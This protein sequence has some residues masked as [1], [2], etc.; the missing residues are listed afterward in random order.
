MRNCGERHL[1]P[2]RHVFAS[3]TQV[4]HSAEHLHFV[5]DGS[6]P[7]VAGWDSGTSDCVGA[8]DKLS[9]QVAFFWLNP[10]DVFSASLLPD[11]PNAKYLSQLV[12]IIVLRQFLC[13]FLVYPARN[14]FCVEGEPVGYFGVAHAQ[15]KPITSLISPWCIPAIQLHSCFDFSSWEGESW[16][17]PGS[18]AG[19]GTLWVIWVLW[20]WRN[21]GHMPSWMFQRST[22]QAGYIERLKQLGTALR[23]CIVSVAGV[24]WGNVIMRVSS[25][26]RI[27]LVGKP[28]ILGV[29]PPIDH[30]ILPRFTFHTY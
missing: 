22:L 14:V 13:L 27:V 8:M 2:Q 9:T 17:S 4:V 11:C 30:L 26:R 16:L 15:I 24:P 25:L 1:G 12:F 10:D 28:L 7:I 18:V 23:F 29:V 19:K 5:S 3:T 6:G 21:Y 20:A